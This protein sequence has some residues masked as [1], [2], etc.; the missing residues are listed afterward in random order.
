VIVVDASS[1]AKVVLLE[2]GWNGVPLTT[3]TA[4]LSHSII[5]VS[6]SIWR[7]ALRGRIGEEEA[8]RKLDAL[9]MIA[10]AI[11]I[12]KAEDYLERGFEIALKEKITVYDAIY[13]A[14]A[15]GK[16]AALY[17]SDRKQYGV[18]RRYVKATFVG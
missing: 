18:A 1:L 12:F 10:D 7:A 17:T 3:D 9:R 15:E 4:T 11:L 13:I 6:S 8:K 16:K 2:E 5:E 14:L